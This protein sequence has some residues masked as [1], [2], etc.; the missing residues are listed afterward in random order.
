MKRDGYNPSTPPGSPTA[1]RPAGNDPDAGKPRNPAAT[2]A[3]TGATLDLREK[4][5]TEAIDRR[6]FMQLHVYRARPGVSVSETLDRAMRLLDE[7][8]LP[9]VLY[10]DVNDPTGFALLSWS[11]DP[12][13]FVKRIRPLAAEKILPHAEMDRDFSMLG[14]T[15]SSG[16]ERDVAAWIIDR[17]IQNVSNPQWPWAVWYPLRRTG[18]FERVERAEQVAMLKEHAQIGRQYG[19]QGLAHDVRLACHGLDR[20]D[21]EFVVGLIG[22]DLHPLS[23]VVESMRTTRQTSE[24]MQHMGPFFVGH[25]YWQHGPG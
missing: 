15:Y 7:Q 19:M 4:G 6:L 23:H 22:Q 25:V 1:G 9:S 14:R 17:P 16:Y 21:N 11:E 18:A 20:N 3:P 12:A 2:A 24:Y 10:E 13:H 8:N 5:A